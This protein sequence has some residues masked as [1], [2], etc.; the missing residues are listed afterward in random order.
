MGRPLFIGIVGKACN[1]HLPYEAPFI[2]PGMGAQEGG[3]P[4]PCLLSSS[5][6]KPHG[7]Q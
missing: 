3:T 2:S 5:T 6:Q 4:L 1:R 7:L